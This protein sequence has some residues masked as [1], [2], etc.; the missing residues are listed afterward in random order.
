MLRKCRYRSTG[1][2]MG[3]TKIIDNIKD[4]INKKKGNLCSSSDPSC[5]APSNFHPKQ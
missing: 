2:Q 5:F 1:G 4:N 3:R